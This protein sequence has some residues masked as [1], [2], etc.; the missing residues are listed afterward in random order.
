MKDYILIPNHIKTSNIPHGAKILYGDILSLSRDGFCFA[1]NKY[2]AQTY[3]VHINSIS[4][5]ITSLKDKKFIKAK[6]GK[7]D[8][9]RST[10]KIYPVIRCVKKHKK[11][12]K[13]NNKI[14]EYKGKT[15]VVI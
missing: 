11:L 5:W 13:G 1:S 4:N 3:N 12:L 2:F 15:K 9:G 8:E 14:Y 6:Y 7:D 10:R